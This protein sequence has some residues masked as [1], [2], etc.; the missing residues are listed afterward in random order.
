MELEFWQ[1]TEYLIKNIKQDRM[2]HATCI[3]LKLFSFIKLNIL[4]YIKEKLTSFLSTHTWK[5]IRGRLICFHCETV[6]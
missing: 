4:N 5:N 1:V 3:E 6:P 2:D